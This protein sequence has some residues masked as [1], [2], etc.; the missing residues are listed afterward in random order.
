[1]KLLPLL[2]KSLCTRDAGYHSPGDKDHGPGNRF[3]QQRGGKK[4]TEKG[5]E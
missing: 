3:M 1:M 2:S 4:E 5:L